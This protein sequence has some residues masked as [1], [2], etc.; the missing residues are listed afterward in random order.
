L[1]AP[2]SAWPRPLQCASPGLPTAGGRS[3]SETGPGPV[4]A[5]RPGGLPGP[6]IWMCS[7]PSAISSTWSS[8]STATRRLRLV[9]MI[10]L[11]KALGGGW[12]P[13]DAAQRNRRGHPGLIAA[14]GGSR[15]LS[16]WLHTRR[17]QGRP[18]THYGDDVQTFRGLQ[19]R[20]LHA[21]DAQSARFANRTCLPAPLQAP[22]SGCTG[23]APAHRLLGVAPGD[24]SWVAGPLHPPLAGSAAFR[25]QPMHARAS[26]WAV[27]PCR[28]LQ[29][30]ANRPRWVSTASRRLRDLVRT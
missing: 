22:R 19:T 28:W 21:S 10:Q 1:E 14:P 3:T 23:P 4:R 5:D 30:S 24:G 11:Y 7:R 6:T 16:R 8:R 12:S 2:A 15:F 25:Q 17:L 29:F 20:A 13:S 18:S 27:N 9:S 26:P